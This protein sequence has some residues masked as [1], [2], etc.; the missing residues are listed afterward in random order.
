MTN[1]NPNPQ[2]MIAYHSSVGDKENP[3]D[4]CVEKM[5]KEAPLLQY[6]AEQRIAANEGG[7][8]FLAEMRGIRVEMAKMNDKI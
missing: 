8:G 6:D 1:P 2:G 3:L 7:F 4:A 5:V